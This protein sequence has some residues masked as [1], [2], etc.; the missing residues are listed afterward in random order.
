MWLFNKKVNAPQRIILGMFA[1]GSPPGPPPASWDCDGPWARLKSCSLTRLEAGRARRTRLQFPSAHTLSRM[2]K[3]P[4]GLHRRHHHRPPCS[5]VVCSP[6]LRQ[7]T[8]DPTPRHRPGP[9]SSSPLRLSGRPRAVVRWRAAG[10]LA[11]GTGKS[12]T[13][14]PRRPSLGVDFD[15]GVV[16][17]GAVLI[18]GDYQVLAATCP[19]ASPATWRP[20]DLG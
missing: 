10:L 8:R 2:L 11:V 3:A 5:D 14:H 7:G 1:I 9:P 6:P 20:V 15:Y 13:A 4:S 19:T 16:F 18:D 17:T 12:S